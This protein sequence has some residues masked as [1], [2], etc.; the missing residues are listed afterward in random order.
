MPE[1]TGTGVCEREKKR[2]LEALTACAGN[3]TRAAERLKKPRRTF[4]SKLGQLGI[5]RPRKR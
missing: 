4:V 3:Q 1:R 5:E 2:I